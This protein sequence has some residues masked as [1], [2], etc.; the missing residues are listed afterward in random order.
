MTSAGQTGWASQPDPDPTPWQD[1]RPPSLSTRPVRPEGEDLTGQ[2]VA[3]Q[4]PS[5][6]ETISDPEMLRRL[7]VSRSPSPDQLIDDDELARLVAQEGVSPD[8]YLVNGVNVNL[9]EL[10]LTDVY[11]VGP[12]RVVPGQDELFVPCRPEAAY[13]RHRLDANTPDGS[14]VMPVSR[15][16]VEVELPEPPPVA[17]G[18]ELDT[19]TPQQRM[20]ARARDLADWPERDPV[21]AQTVHPI[22]GRRAI[23]ARPGRVEL[24]HTGRALS[25]VGW[26]P[27][28]ELSVLTCTEEQWW[29]WQLYRA[30]PETLCTVPAFAVWVY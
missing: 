27:T 26:S 12:T 2:R 20:L 29:R 28:K 15:V 9:R 21:S 17:F 3:I 14:W 1:R 5:E 25:E 30:M 10:I 6:D 18:E 16:R 7:K 8:E 13:W 24:W 19:R 11:G 22:T 23:F 4:V